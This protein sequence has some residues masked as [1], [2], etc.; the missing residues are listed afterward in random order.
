MKELLSSLFESVWIP[1]H[2]GL[3]FG[4]YR[5]GAP[6]SLVVCCV[7]SLWTAYCAGKTDAHRHW[8]KEFEKHHEFMRRLLP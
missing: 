1:I 7:L 2:A 5:A 4:A 3:L 6:I 8:A